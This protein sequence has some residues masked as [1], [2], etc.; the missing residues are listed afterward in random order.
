MIIDMINYMN[1]QEFLVFIFM[2]GIFSGLLII[3]V[4][5]FISKL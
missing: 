3:F 2:L 5:Y 1:Y 4:A